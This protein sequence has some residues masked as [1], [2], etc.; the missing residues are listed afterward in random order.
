[1]GWKSM[2]EPMEEALVG[3]AGPAEGRGSPK[4]M[5][6][7]GRRGVSDASRRG[8]IDSADRDSFV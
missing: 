8:R 6:G 7:V 4:M 1:M 2:R 3:C 5:D